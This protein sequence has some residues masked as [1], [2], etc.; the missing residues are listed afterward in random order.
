M[1][2]MVRAVLDAE[3]RV[4]ELQDALLQALGGCPDRR[5]PT[6]TGCCCLTQ[7]W[8]YGWAD[9]GLANSLCM[10]GLGRRPPDLQV[11]DDESAILRE[12]HEVAFPGLEVIPHRRCSLHVYSSAESEW[13]VH[14]GNAF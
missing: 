3:G 2:A 7:V 1:C 4:R 11:T 5:E 14:S 6:V 13:R 9:L 12:P 10:W 8:T